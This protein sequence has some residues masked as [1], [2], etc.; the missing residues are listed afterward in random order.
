MALHPGG[1]PLWRR[2]GVVCGGDQVDVSQKDARGWYFIAPDIDDDLSERNSG[3]VVER[4]EQVRRLS[5]GAGP[6]VDGEG[7]ASTSTRPVQG[8]SSHADHKVVNFQVTEPRINLSGSL[9]L[10]LR[11]MSRSYAT[12]QCRAIKHHDSKY[13]DVMMP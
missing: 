4:G 2:D 13:N 1:Q 7:P 9:L 11:R 5:L 10:R 3:T 6:L 12:A 8:V